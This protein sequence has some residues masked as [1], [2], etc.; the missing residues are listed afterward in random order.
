MRHGRRRIRHGRGV[1]FNVALKARRKTV[2]EKGP[3]GF[4]G[5]QLEYTVCDEGYLEDHSHT[6][7]VCYEPVILFASA[8]AE[9]DGA[10]G[11]THYGYLRN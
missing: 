4:Q 5:W 1:V 2:Y 6:T 9:N 10:R 7:A 11:R 8:V 3:Q